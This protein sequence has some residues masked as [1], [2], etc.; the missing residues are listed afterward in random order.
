MERFRV[1]V[2]ALSDEFDL[3][4]IALGAIKM[5]HEATLTGAEG[6]DQEIPVE[7]YVKEKKRPD[8]S[9][10]PGKRGQSRTGGG[11]TRLFI[12]VGRSAGVRPKD[13]VGAI[14]GESGIRGSQIGSIQISE[15]FSLVEVSDH[16]AD[17]VMQALRN[18]KIKGK[19]VKVRTDRIG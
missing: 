8:N 2:E 7:K 12:G 6:D 18:G 15:R 13:L 16:V 10:S 9:Y 11:V 14:T 1:V 3:F 5:G 17:Q 19:K 4:D